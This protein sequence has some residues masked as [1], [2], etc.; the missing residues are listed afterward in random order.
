M[1]SRR[2]HGQVNVVVT[3]LCNSWE[4]DHGTERL[5][6]SSYRSCVRMACA[7]KAEK[8]STALINYERERLFAKG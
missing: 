1:S 6:E 5:L 7:L 4:S 8:K 2:C 3:F